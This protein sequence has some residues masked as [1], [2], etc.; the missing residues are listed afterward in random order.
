MLLLLNKII[1]FSIIFRYYYSVSEDLTYSL[2]I[3]EVEMHYAF[4]RSGNPSL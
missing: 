3:I 2:Y 1:A 4:I